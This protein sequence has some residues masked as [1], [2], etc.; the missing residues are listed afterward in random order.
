MNI[1]HYPDQP[2]LSP[3]GS[4]AWVD[5]KTTTPTLSAPK[6]S[7]PTLE[8]L[9]SPTYDDEEDWAPSKE[10]RCIVFSLQ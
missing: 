7:R 1:L 6:G 8:P 9:I 5:K 10:Y 4:R 2:I 3:V